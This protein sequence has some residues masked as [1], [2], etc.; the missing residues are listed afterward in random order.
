MVF[1]L[2]AI[3]THD[4]LIVV[5]TLPEELGLVLG[6]TPEVNLSQHLLEDGVDGCRQR[7]ESKAHNRHHSRAFLACLYANSN[8]QSTVEISA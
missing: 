7:E 3:A 6:Q 2:A 5:S 8:R 1:Q 4:L